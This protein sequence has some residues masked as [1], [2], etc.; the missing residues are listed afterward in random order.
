VVE[1]AEQLFA[2]LE[3]MEAVPQRLHRM[4][5]QLKVVGIVV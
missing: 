1:L 4:A 5:D 2:V 3:G